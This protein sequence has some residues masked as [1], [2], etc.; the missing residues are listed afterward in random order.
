MTDL[1]K[2]FCGTVAILG[3]GFSVPAGVPSTNRISSR[4]LSVDRSSLTPQP[5]Q[6]RM[7]AHLSQY[8]RDVFQYQGGDFRPSFEDHFTL[9]DLSANTGHYL[10]G[11][12]PA[13]LRALRRI[14][15][16][17][18]F[19]ILF[20]S[21]RHS[22]SIASFLQQF[23]S[24]PNTSIVSLKWDLVLE[25]HLNSL[26]IPYQYGI[27]G[28]YLDRQELQAVGHRITKLHGSINWFYCDKCHSAAFGHPL[29][30]TVLH[31]RCLL[32][33]KDFEVLQPEN[34]LGR[35]AFEPGAMAVPC[36][37]KCGN[38]CMTCR[39]AT[40]SHTKSTDFYFFHSSWD[41]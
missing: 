40:F 1:I 39:V 11:Y 2:D 24:A 20:G 26:R 33:P 31:S 14:S 25:N 27:P 16:H 18:V 21:Y 23:T 3:A 37:N 12:K 35:A 22:D 10:G 32:L 41:L 8:W 7:S 36:P 19:D 5:I 34:P 15:I 17:R 29:S 28:E 6:E 38:R 30:K 13:M 4:F 9:L